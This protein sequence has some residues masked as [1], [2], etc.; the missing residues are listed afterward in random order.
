ETVAKKLAAALKSIDRIQSATQEE[1]LGIDEIGERIAS[2]I[3][4]YFSSEENR[5]MI[6]Q[7]RNFGLKFE[8]VSSE[9]TVLSSSLEGQSIV[10]SGVF[11][12]SRDELKALIEAH[13]GK[14]VS[15]IT[16]KTNFVLAG[17]NMGPAKYEKAQKLN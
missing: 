5:E 15:S 7:L 10:V 8:Q 3:V 12:R 9:E 13:G 2:S 14:N 4:S 11:S 16:G 1:L 6:V 17:D